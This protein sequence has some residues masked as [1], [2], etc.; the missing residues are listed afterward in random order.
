MLVK[1]D[2]YYYRPTEVES[3]R[4]DCGRARDMLGCN[5]RI[6]FKDLV[7]VMV[8]ADM[9]GVGQGAQR[10]IPRQ[11]VEEGFIERGIETYLSRLFIMVS[12]LY[13]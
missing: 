13:G 5:A 1:T 3:L 12:V 10:E 11:L 6:K 9:R 4:A 2:P 7:R 8:D